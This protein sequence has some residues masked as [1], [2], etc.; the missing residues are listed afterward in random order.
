MATKPKAKADKE[1]EE[2]TAPKVLT[3]DDK[4]Q[5]HGLTKGE[6]K[7][8]HRKQIEGSVEKIPANKGKNIKDK[9]FAAEYEGYEIDEHEKQILHVATEARSFNQATGQKLSSSFVQ[10]YDVPTFERMSKQEAFKGYTMHILHDP[11]ELKE[12]EEEET[13]D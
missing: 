5:A 2:N 1:G 13:E 10:K 4:L 8:I 3:E 7:I 12:E 6:M 9:H 11:R